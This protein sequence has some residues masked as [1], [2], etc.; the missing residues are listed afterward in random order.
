M[1]DNIQIVD[2]ILKKSGYGKE[3]VIPILQAIQ[4]HYNYLPEDV[5]QEVCKRSEISLSRIVGVASFYSQFR[6][7]PAGRHLIKVCV[8]TA[9]HVKGALQVFDA[10]SR[11]LKLDFLHDTDKEGIFTLQKVACLGC[12]TL[13]PAVQIDNVTYGK[14][15]QNDISGIL[16]NFLLNQNKIESRNQNKQQHTF[17]GEIR[18]GLGSC[19][20]ASGSEDVKR[21]VVAALV[22]T[23][24]NPKIKQVGCVGMCH[25]VPLLEIIPDGKPGVTYAKVKPG[26]VRKI[27][28]QHFTPSGFLNRLKNKLVQGFENIYIDV[29]E[30]SEHCFL[31]MKEKQVADFFN[32][33]V[34]VATAEKGVL[35]PLDIDEYKEKNG[36]AAL[37]KCLK[38]LSATDIIEIIKESGLR[39]RGGAGFPTGSKW[40]I[41]GRQSSPLKYII[42]N[43]DEGDPGAFMDRMLLESFPFRVIEGM[44]IAG[45]ATGAVKGVFYI[46]AEYQ[47]AV[48]RIKEALSICRQNKLLGHHVAGS[49]FNFDIDIFEGAGA[50]VCG[51]ET[52][53]IA[54]MEGKR[55]MPSVRP[56]YP[57]IKGFKN[58]PTLVNNVETFSN[59][60]YIILNGP[61]EFNKT[62]TSGSK[63]TKVFA[64]A[65]KIARGGLIEV[66]MGITIR[67]VIEEIGGGIQG[68][69][70]FK[71]VQIGGPS[72]GCIP[73]SLSGTPIDYQYL[74]DA[75]AMMGSGGLVVLDET[76][77]IV[78]I[79][80]YFLTFTRDQSCGKCVFCRVGTKHLLHLLENISAGKAK[81]EDLDKLEELALQVSKGSLCGLGK[82]APNPILT[83]LKYFREEYEAHIYGQCP[84]KKC[85]NL[86]TYSIN[87]KCIGCTKCARDCPAGAIAFQPYELHKINQDK[88]IKCDICRQVCPTEAVEI[89]TGVL[90]LK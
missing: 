84:A 37:M 40:E 82:T 50:F 57:V 48:S 52:A 4:K 72:G 10:F 83:T 26:E 74:N 75:G 27:L 51:E 59:I 24:I 49:D 54:S 69:K 90:N 32:K 20:V 70:K 60:P 34:H 9:C 3:K 62:G 47:L 12:C 18:L 89:L 66:P 79:A 15:G 7:A 22:N 77:C 53:L 44:I 43:G 78:D 56:P 19:C 64:L 39:G 31:D 55:G 46:R 11:H 63:G 76:D 88:C 71:A 87:D 5:L 86:I 25:Q 45:F 81:I 36:F 58:V 29:S 14:V 80:K 6:L 33:Q 23:G 65:G 73:E 42:C 68:N 2:E 30:S 38:S 85:K 41:I 28:L 61:D 8:G 13:A 17:D 67:E 35:N 21:A 1:T 16:D